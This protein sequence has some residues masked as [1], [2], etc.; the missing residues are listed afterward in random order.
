VIGGGRILTVAIGAGLSPFVRYALQG[1]RGRPTVLH[2]WL[3]DATDEVIV[4]GV[5]TI[6][7][8][9]DAQVGHVRAC[10][11]ARVL[12]KHVVWGALLGMGEAV[13]LRWWIELCDEYGN[14]LARR[15]VTYVYRLPERKAGR[16]SPDVPARKRR[17]GRLQHRGKGAAG[18]PGAGSGTGVALPPPRGVLRLQ[19][20]G[21]R[22]GSA[23]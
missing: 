18:A 15:K 12:H 6:S 22:A 8:G 23:A 2:C 5:A 19:P 4:E 1:R 21:D 11:A 16:A 20:Q 9:S 3:V 17:E 13:W 14:R 7:A 10:A